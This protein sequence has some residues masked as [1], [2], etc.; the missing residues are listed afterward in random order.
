VYVNFLGIEGEARIR[1]AYSPET[2]RRLAAVKRRYDP[3]N[4]FRLN[5]NVKPLPDAATAR[6]AGAR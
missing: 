3:T 2:Y 5:Q 4:F 6:A 1:E